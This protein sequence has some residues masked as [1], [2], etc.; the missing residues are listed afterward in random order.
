MMEQQLLMNLGLDCDLHITTFQL[1]HTLKEAMTQQQYLKAKLDE[2]LT[3]VEE[4]WQTMKET[5]TLGSIKIKPKRGWCLRK[6]EGK[7]RE[8]KKK[9]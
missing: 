2:H 7:G 8:K 5:K 4:Q 6:K 1:V 9:C 3:E